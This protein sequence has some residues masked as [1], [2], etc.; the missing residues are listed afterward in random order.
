[1]T[2]ED[3]A[4]T[5]RVDFLLEMYKQ[6][7]S[8]LNRHVSAMWQCVAVIAAAAAV[9]RVEQSSPMFDLSVC[10]AIT[11]CAWLMASTYDACNWFNRNI[12]IISNIEKLFLETDD[13]RKVHPYF[14]RGM[15]PGKVIGHFKIQ[16]YLAGCVATVL[17]LGHFYLRILPGFF[18]KGCVIEPLRGLP[19]LM[20]IIA[21]VFIKNL[22]TQHIEHEKDFAQRSPGIG[23]S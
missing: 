6:C 22:R 13:L 19:Y 12:A 17:L 14:D 8:H 23:V 18:A 9:L 7:S 16:L 20:A 2:S 1:M 21:M 3:Q 10:I 15:R 5:Q 11:L 4:S